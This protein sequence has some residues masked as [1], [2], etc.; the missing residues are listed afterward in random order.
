MFTVAAPGLYRLSYTIN[1]TAALAAGTRLVINGTP[2]T[3][4]T[5]SPGLSISRFNNEIL[6]NLPAG[7][8]ISLEMYGL[9]AAAVLLP[10]SLGASLQ[11]VRLS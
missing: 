6:V 1:T 3:A 2:N 11:I 4:S 5:L 8:T 9:L 7:S 10:G